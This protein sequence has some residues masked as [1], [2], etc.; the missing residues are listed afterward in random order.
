MR[1]GVCFSQGK[2]CLNG[3]EPI[4]LVCTKEVLLLSFFSRCHPFGQGRNPPPHPPPLSTTAPEQPTLRLL[5]LLL[6]PALLSL[7]QV[8]PAVL[9]NSTILRGRSE[10]IL[11]RLLLLLFGFLGIHLLQLLGLPA[12]ARLNRHCHLQIRN[13]GGLTFLPYLPRRPKTVAAPQKTN[14][15]ASLFPAT[16]PPAGIRIHTLSIFHP[17]N[18]ADSVH[19]LGPV[20]R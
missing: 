14:G 3:K 4:I 12:P 19:F 13:S 11:L 18:C 20:H 2:G 7:V 6:L 1:F 17:R 9:V 15:P 16:N 5:L 10:R 8:P